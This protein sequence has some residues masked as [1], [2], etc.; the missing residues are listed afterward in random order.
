[1]SKLKFKKIIMFICFK[2]TIVKIKT[3]GG[4]CCQWVKK[5]LL[6]PEIF[7]SED[8]SAYQLFQNIHIQALQ[9]K[10]LLTLLLKYVL[11]YGTVH[12]ITVKSGWNRGEK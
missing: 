4:T 10:N 12:Y 9:F 2:N 8:V 6:Y 5:C 1:M 7:S 3:V 11:A